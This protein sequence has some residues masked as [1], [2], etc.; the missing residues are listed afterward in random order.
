MDILFSSNFPLPSETMKSKPAT[1]ASSMTIA[2]SRQ[3]NVGVT[4]YYHYISRCVRR[5]FLCGE[6]SFTGKC[7]DHRRQWLVDRFKELAQIFSVH[8]PAY[9]VLSNHHNLV[10]RVDGKQATCWTDEEVSERWRRNSRST[11]ARRC[12]D[13]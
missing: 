13:A 2:R 10:L 5:A 6:D 8:T 12:H 9:E 3:V 11:S 7:F 4:S 1:G